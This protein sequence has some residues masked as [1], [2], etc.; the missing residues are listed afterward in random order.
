M[1]VAK[2][3]GSTNSLWRGNPKVYRWFTLTAAA[4]GARN[5]LVEV[6]RGLNCFHVFVGKAEMVAKFMDK[7]M[8]DDFTQRIVVMLGPIVENGAPIE[9]KVLGN[10]PVCGTAP[11]SVMPMPL[12]RPMSSNGLSMP[13]PSST[14]SSAKSA[15]EQVTSAASEAK[16]SGRAL[17]A[18]V[19]SASMSSR[20][21]A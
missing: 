11:S 13:K 1:I 5:R 6:G 9:E 14:S 2:R 16:G 19:A 10:W 15:T 7:Y 12:N 21:G 17:S 3:S 20:V 4:P 18:S 8:G